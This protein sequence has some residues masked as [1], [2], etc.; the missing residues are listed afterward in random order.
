[1]EL[2][3][4]PHSRSESEGEWE[5][6]WMRCLIFIFIRAW[7]E[8]LA[9][10]GLWGLIILEMCKVKC[11]DYCKHGRGGGNSLMFIWLQPPS[12]MWCQSVHFSVRKS[13]IV[14]GP[15]I[16]SFQYC[17]M[18]LQHCRDFMFPPV[19]VLELTKPT[20][21]VHHHKAIEEVKSSFLVGGFLK[22]F[23]Y[24]QQGRVTVIHNTRIEISLY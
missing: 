11:I 8:S 7:F 6:I 24:L 4:F 20:K 23:F 1:M 14:V 18:I 21:D 13:W 9:P 12:D 16:W 17:G 15:L 3:K 19:N 22:V 10:I 5:V 2:A